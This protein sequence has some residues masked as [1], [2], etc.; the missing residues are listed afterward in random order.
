MQPLQNCICPSIRI[1]QEV[2]CLPY[3]GFFGPN[4]SKLYRARKLVFEHKL[5]LS[6]EPEPSLPW[7]S[8]FLLSP[9]QAQLGYP[10]HFRAQAETGWGFQF[11]TKPS[12]ARP[13]QTF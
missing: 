5:E 6:S 13:A 2:L 1:G 4:P 12:R 11:V 7:N 10:T 8:H 3:A 9:S